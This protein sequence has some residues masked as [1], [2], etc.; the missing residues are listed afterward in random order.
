M[1]PIFMD[2]FNIKIASLAVDFYSFGCCF[3]I[4][5]TFMGGEF[6]SANAKKL[7]TNTKIAVIIQIVQITQTIHKRRRGECPKD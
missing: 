3:F 7:L 6:I 4:L 5:H 1:S 2:L